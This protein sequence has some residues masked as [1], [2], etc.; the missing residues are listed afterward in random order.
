MSEL[1]ECRNCY[2]LGL[3]GR[4]GECQRCQSRQVM[5]VD[6]IDVL[7][8]PSLTGVERENDVEMAL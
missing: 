1:Y 6:L 3:L 2:S 8:N 7:L 4:H 5:S